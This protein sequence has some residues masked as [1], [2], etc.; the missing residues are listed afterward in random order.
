MRYP[1]RHLRLRAR[2]ALPTAVLIGWSTACVGS[3]ANENDETVEA[4]PSALTAATA[5]P[6]GGKEQAY[7]EFLQR[8][9]QSAGGGVSTQRAVAGGPSDALEQY[10]AKCDLAT[11]VHVPAFSCENGT[12]VPDQGDGV[13]CGHPNVLNNECDP[14]SKFQVLVRTADAIVVAH[15]RKRVRA[16][17]LAAPGNTL[18]NDIAVIQYNKSNG[19]QCFYQALLGNGVSLNGAAV[20]APSMGGNAG[21]PWISPQGTEGIN[22]TGCHDD[23]G[24]MRSEYLAQ[25]T[26]GKDAFPNANTGF[27]NNTIPVKYVGLDFALNRSWSITGP[28]VV[29]SGAPCTT[30][31][32]LAVANYLAFG[33]INGTGGHFARQAT[34]TIQSGAITTTTDNNN[35]T[36]SIP[37]WM[38]PGQAAY[39]ADAEASAA[40]FEACA[41]GCWNSGPDPTVVDPNA[42]KD[43]FQNCAATSGCTFTLLA[44]SW[45][46]ISPAPLFAAMMVQM[47]L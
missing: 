4:A 37:R 29:G 41:V 26:T 28:T 8:S 10:A 16:G 11:G 47:F 34:Q 19:A 20:T 18:Y 46:G 17:G 12:E 9:G 43:G 36:Y 42:Q 45:D 33:R 25:L 35:F 14:G 44:R 23:G 31:H 3:V 21:F 15:C 40:K 30:C 24:L 1:S 38:R 32:R 27:D 13:T 2:I 22:C 6:T 39:D 5:V 7:A